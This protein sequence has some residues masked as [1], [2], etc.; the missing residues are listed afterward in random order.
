MTQT[1]PEK[2]AYFS[3]E[4]ILSIALGEYEETRN[5]SQSLSIEKHVHLCVGAGVG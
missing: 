5:G 4:K 1:E 3:C 2:G